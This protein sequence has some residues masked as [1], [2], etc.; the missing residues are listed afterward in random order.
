MHPASSAQ[1]RVRLDNCLTGCC[2]T[3]TYERDSVCVCSINASL[4]VELR[5]CAAA[6]QAVVQIVEDRSSRLQYAVKFFLSTDAF[7]QEKGMYLAPNQPLGAFLPQLHT[8]IE[9]SSAEGPILDSAGNALPPCIVM[10]KGEALDLWT[11]S[12]GEGLDMVT[13]LQVPSHPL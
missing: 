9:P 11:K 10:E 13:G 7:L 2:C 6:G 8:I 12:S 5:A 4:E 1:L 3:C